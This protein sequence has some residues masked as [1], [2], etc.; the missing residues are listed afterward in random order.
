MNLYLRL[1]STYLAARRRGPL[2]IW[3]TAKTPFRVL[4]TDLDVLR[5]M[6][7]GRYLSLLDLGRMDHMLRSGFWRLITARGWYPVVAGQTV[8]YR[9]SLELWQRFEIHSRVLGVDDRWVYLEQTF[10]RGETVHAEAIVRA[11][12]LRRSGGSVPVEELA[13][14]IGGVPDDRVVPE[15]ITEWTTRSAAWGRKD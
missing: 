13:E 5:H 9:K 4:P 10:R 15:W 8:T 11:R 3:D 1:L 12:F 14:V 7:N 2:G 6:N